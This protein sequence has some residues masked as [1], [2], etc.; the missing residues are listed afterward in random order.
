VASLDGEKIYK[1]S[2]EPLKPGDLVYLNRDVTVTATVVQDS[3]GLYCVGSIGEPICEEYG[4]LLQQG[5]V[6]EVNKVAEGQAELVGFDT[7]IESSFVNPETDEPFWEN[8]RID[9]VAVDLDIVEK[10]PSEGKK[11]DK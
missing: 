7:L 8:V 1:Q 11:E 6:A 9:L 5:M 4:I 10:I 2:T 3:N